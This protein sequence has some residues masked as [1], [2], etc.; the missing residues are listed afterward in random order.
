[1][2]NLVVILIR[3]RTYTRAPSRAPPSR[4]GGGYDV[5]LFEMMKMQNEKDNRKTKI[6]TSITP[7]NI[8]SDGLLLLRGGITIDFMTTTCQ[9]PVGDMVNPIMMFYSDTIANTDKAVCATCGG[10]IPENRPVFLMS[11]GSHLYPCADEQEWIWWT[12]PARDVKTLK[13]EE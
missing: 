2:Y 13:G 12:V 4:S 5:S 6:D 11:D 9:S 3:A 1:M 7:L 10:A 8:T